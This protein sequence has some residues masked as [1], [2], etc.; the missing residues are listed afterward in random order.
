MRTSQVSCML[1]MGSPVG[2]ERAMTIT[3][4]SDIDRVAGAISGTSII[5]YPLPSRYNV[6]SSITTSPSDRSGTK[7]L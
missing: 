6:Q 1:D 5:Y 7:E 2:R 4:I 3:L